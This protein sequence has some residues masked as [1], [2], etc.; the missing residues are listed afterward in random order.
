[1]TVDISISCP[2]CGVKFRILYILLGAPAGCVSC[3][4]LFVAD[5]GLGTVFPVTVCE[6]RFGAFR[7]LAKDDLKETSRLLEEVL[8]Y[9]IQSESGFVM[10][11]NSKGELV[12]PLMIHLEIQNDP[13]LQRRFYR[14][15][16]SLW[17]F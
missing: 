16:L 2:S 17:R 11:K 14:L 3:G 1:M 12:D 6:M 8:G 7:N 4:A 10:Y 15:G 5:V 13:E 9:T